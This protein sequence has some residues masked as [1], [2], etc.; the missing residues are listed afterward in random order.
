MKKKYSPWSLGYLLFFLLLPLLGHAQG[1]VSI[2]VKGMV[3]DETGTPLIGVTLQLEG[4]SVASITDIDGNYELRGEVNEGT[5]QLVTGYIGYA[6]STYAL[7]VGAGNASF[8][9]NFELNPDLLNLDEVVVTGNTSTTTRKSLGNNV[10][11]LKAENLKNAA[12]TN[13]LGALQGKVMGAQITQNSGDPAGGV[14]V[15]LRGASSIN[16]SSDPLYIIDG[17]IVDNSSQNVINRNA[18]AQTTSF[19]AGQNR[20]VDLNSSDI[21]RIEVLNGAS[22]AALYGARA[23]NGVIQI[24]TKRGKAE[25]LRVEFSTSLITSE[26]RKEIPMSNLGERF[27]KK[28]NDRLETAQDRLTILLTVG[29]TDAQLNTQ[30]VKFVKAGYTPRTLVTDKYAV[31][32]YNYWDDIFQSAIGSENNLSFSGGN[33]K[34]QFYASLGYY[35]NQGIVKNTNFKRYNLRLNLDQ[36]LA[37]WAKLSFGLGSNLSRSQDMPN[38]NNFFNPI[39][40]VFIIDNVWNLNDRDAN[41]NLRQVEQ[42]RINPLSIIETFDIS[43]QT[44]RT[45]GNIKL[46]LFPVKGL[47]IDLIGGGDIYSLQ[48]NEYHP[49]LPYSG[50]SADFFPDGYVSL[51]TD[52]LMLFNQDLNVTYNKKIGESLSS[53]TMA[54]YQIQYNR[55]QYAAQD[56]RDLAPFGRTIA[57]A[58]N[59]FNRPVQSISERFI[60]GAFVQQTFGWKEQVFVTLAGRIDK[61]S[62]FAEDNQNNF[63]PKVSGSWV[64]SDYLKNKNLISSAK[65]RAAYGQAGNLTGIGAYDRFDN[66]LLSSIGGL[67]SITPS[68]TFANPSV[69]PEKMTEFEFGGDFAFLKNRLG[70]SFNVYSQ[71]ITDLLLTKPVPPSVGG[72]SIVTNVGESTYM[73][74][75]GFE[76]MLNASLVR[77]QKFKWDLGILYNQNRNRVYGIDGGFFYLR[78]NGPQAVLNGHSF[79]AFYGTYYARAQNGDFLK[80]TQG[81]FQPERGTQTTALQG[82]VDR[83]SDG[84]PKTT[85]AGS[86]ELRKVIGDPTPD[87]TGSL[88]T[89]IS[90]KKLSLYVLFDAV[91]GGDVYNWNR[92]TSNNV[93]WGPLAQQEIRGEVPRGT[94]ASVA[95]GINGGRIQEEHVEDGSF[96]K[97]RELALAYELGKVKGL[98][99]NF[100]ISI[101]GRNLWSFDNYQG[102]DP[103]ANSAGQSDRVRGDDFGA[104]PIP[105]TIMVRLNGRF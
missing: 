88:N 25:K 57:A 45:M 21:E 78:P 22:A 64:L 59:L 52:N 43:Q 10:S 90:Y 69:R 30:N 26:L 62:V 72:T 93:G 35:D 75:K 9:H 103:E 71:K 23:A 82:T 94:V 91:I 77:T 51:A 101:I 8:E 27:G 97:V 36:T 85:G 20:L 12:T 37:S 53:T 81:L 65:V 55:R 99:D 49:R 16:G 1:K 39:S 105:R 13:S 95:G 66:Y 48:G 80:T 14:S 42:V 83:G 68:T 61:S 46:S 38:G 28:G 100:N 104:V 6:K 86:T 15:R 44:Y 29:L 70:L 19:Q 74:N 63:Y 18:D 92:I 50:V 7:T 34:T 102:F 33:D 32:R 3:K 96:V 89:N 58:N 40:G 60:S 67:A 84:Q 98:F 56:G 2:S 79:G 5:Y 73:D 41:G 24:F 4:T 11:V 47:N 31:Q 54:G 17:I 76:L 87:W